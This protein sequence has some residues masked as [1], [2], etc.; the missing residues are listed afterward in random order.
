LDNESKYRGEFGQQLT[1]VALGDLYANILDHGY[2]GNP[3]PKEDDVHKLLTY[4]DI[5]M[6]DFCG[7]GGRVVEEINKAKVFLQI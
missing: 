7:I 3:F 4:A 1:L 5:S 6:E 2:A